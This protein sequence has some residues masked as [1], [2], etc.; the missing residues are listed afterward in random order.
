MRP[1]LTCVATSGSS[2]DRR[3]VVQH[4]TSISLVP[5]DR[6]DRLPRPVR[7]LRAQPPPPSFGRVARISAIAC[8]DSQGRSEH[9]D[10]L[11]RFTESL[12]A[13]RLLA[14]SR[15]LH[16]AGQPVSTPV[17]AQAP[18]PRFAC[19]SNGRALRAMLPERGDGR[20]PAAHERA[21]HSGRH[22][23]VL[24]AL[25]V[26]CAQPDTVRHGGVARQRE[27][28]AS[29]GGSRGAEPARPVSN[30]LRWPSQVLARRHA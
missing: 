25:D 9:S 27:C 23:I 14:S 17:S 15:A 13:K 24:S 7:S 21:R 20:I 12:R 10:R 30:P 5:H 6:L 2:G 29:F 8:F 28:E 1:A 16:R 19:N 22:G 11:P 4:A 26:D 18:R 3:K